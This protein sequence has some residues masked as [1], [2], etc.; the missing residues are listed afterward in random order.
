ML[1]FAN[2]AYRNHVYVSLEVDE[3]IVREINR[4]MRPQSVLAALSQYRGVAID[5]G[6]TLVILDEIQNCE[7]ALTSLKYFAEEMPELDVM[8]AG[9]LLG[10]AINRKKYSFPVGKVETLQMHPLDFEEYLDAIGK[11]ERA[12]E[13][14]KAFTERIALPEY[15]HEE[16]MRDYRAFLLHGG[17]PA[18]V[19]SRL[20][21]DTF[22]ASRA[23]ANG[24][25]TQYLAD[26]SKYCGSGESVKI[27]MAYDSIPAQL[28]KENTKFQYGAAKKGASSSYFGSAIDWLKASGTVLMCRRIQHGLY[29]PASQMD[30]SAFK[31]Y[32]SD[33]GLLSA[34]TLMTAENLLASPSDSSGFRGAMAENHVACALQSNGHE[35]FYWESD[36]KAEV[37]FVVA[38][39]GA[40]IPIEVKAAENTKSKSLAVYLGKYAAPYAIRMSGKNFGWTE[41][42]HSMPLYAAYLI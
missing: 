18:V 35:L 24:I 8:A 32:M 17:M 19:R 1:Q 5:P 12:L 7:R 41:K 28:A 40:A 36:G 20:G 21:G 2:Q 23:I 26:M 33:V 22:G 3:F 38:R 10:V 29:P 42:I 31:L 16:L 13:I 25:V 4:D 30:V 9:S 37:D 6:N 15:I 27:R 14:R 39:E 34:R 11:Q